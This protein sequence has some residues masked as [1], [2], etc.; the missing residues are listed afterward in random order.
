[1]IM[2]AFYFS[3]CLLCKGKMYKTMEGNNT[4]RETRGMNAIYTHALTRYLSV[5]GQR[6]HQQRMRQAN[7]ALDVYIQERFLVNHFIIIT[8]NYMSNFEHGGL[9]LSSTD[10][11]TRLVYFGT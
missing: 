9:P 11:V 8:E 5:S 10:F 7:G 3:S 2:Y 6:T 1:M 4:S